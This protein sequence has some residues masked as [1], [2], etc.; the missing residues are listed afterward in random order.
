MD[1]HDKL[2]E[3]RRLREKEL[4]TKHEW[5]DLKTEREKLDQ[6]IIEYME[7]RKIQGQKIDGTNFVP[8]E[9]IY[10]QVQDSDEFTQ[11][12]LER[13]DTL[14][15]YKPR[16]EQL[17]ELVRERLDNGEAMPPGLG[18]YVKQTISQRAA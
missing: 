7:H 2:L 8:T 3:R 14:V 15:E 5:E 4:A 13:D 18:F 12:A 16:K 17:N 11:W 10:A 9:T 1:L 6:Q